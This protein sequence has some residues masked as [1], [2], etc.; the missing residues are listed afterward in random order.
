MTDTERLEAL[1]RSAPAVLAGWAMSRRLPASGQ[2][3]IAMKTG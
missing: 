3:Q 1:Y 2:Y